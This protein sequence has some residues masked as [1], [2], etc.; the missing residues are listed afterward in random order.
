MEINDDMNGGRFSLDTLRNPYL[1]GGIAFVLGLIIG[2]VVLGWGL[3]P[4]QWTDAAPRHLAAD[5][6]ED[7]LRMA[8]DSYNLRVDD[9]L[10][11]ERLNALGEAA[12]QILAEVAAKPGEQS[13][14][15]IAKFQTAA[16]AAGPEGAG[17]GV[18]LTPAAGTEEEA[19]T[20]AGGLSVQTILLVACGGTFLLVGAAGLV[21]L[22]TNIR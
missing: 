22:Y 11:Q 20:P 17:G 4:V 18:A 10:A 15:V 14:E 8:I 3:F 6:L 5:Y 13:P 16:G 2:L 9:T 7:Y 12:S 19:A 21:Y 1:I